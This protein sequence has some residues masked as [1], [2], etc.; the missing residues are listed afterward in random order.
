MTEIETPAEIESGRPP[1]QNV[2]FW[3]ARFCN[4]EGTCIDM[5]VRHPAYGDI[6]I[7]INAEEYPLIWAEVIEAGDIAPYVPPTEEDHRLAWRQT[8]S[9]TRAEFCTKLRALN[10]LPRAEAIAAARGDWPA[11]FEPMLEGMSEA[12]QDAAMILWAAIQTVERTHPLFEKV[13]QFFGMTPEQ[14]DDMFD[15]PGV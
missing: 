14:A 12:E 1:L 9:L 13:R 5:M 2:D 15:Y 10:I 8:A 11:S 4:A 7:T 6:P 3:D